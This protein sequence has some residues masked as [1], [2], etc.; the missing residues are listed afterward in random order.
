MALNLNSLTVNKVSKNGCHKP[1]AMTYSDA[2]CPDELGL[3]TNDALERHR[4]SAMRL[5]Q[6]GVGDGDTG[7]PIITMLTAFI[8]LN[9]PDF[10]DLDEPS[11]AEDAQAMWAG[12]LQR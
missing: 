2:Y 3:K 5:S 11:K 4:K 9:T 7:D 1:A 10:L 12:M 8:I 6:V